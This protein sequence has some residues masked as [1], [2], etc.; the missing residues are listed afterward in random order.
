MLPLSAMFRTGHIL[1]DDLCIPY[2]TSSSMDQFHTT[3]SVDRFL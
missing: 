2:H 3:W 1:S